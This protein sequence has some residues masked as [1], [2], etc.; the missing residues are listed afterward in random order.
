M[1]IGK[2]KL[3]KGLEEARRS[4]E[5]SGD[6]KGGRGLRAKGLEDLEMRERGD[7]FRKANWPSTR[8]LSK[9]LCIGHLSIDHRMP[10]THQSRQE[11]GD[12]GL[13]LGARTLAQCFAKKWE[14][15]LQILEQGCC[16]SPFVLKP[17]P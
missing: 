9:C 6:A 1:T 15:K 8:A 5:G 14:G 7:F 10:T 3:Q 11:K 4:W 16:A 13:T 17:K 12:M 2:E